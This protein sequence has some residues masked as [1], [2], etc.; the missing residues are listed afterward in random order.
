VG[1]ARTALFNWLFARHHKG[2][3]ILRIEDTDVAR[4][5]VKMM[6][7]ILESLKWLGLEWDEGPY[8]QSQRLSLYPDQANKLVQKG[9]AYYCYC[10]PEELAKRKEEMVQK[11]KAWKYDRK[12]LDLSD[13]KRKELE[14]ESHPKALRFL[15]REGKTSFE[16]GVHGKIERD[17][18]EIEDFI[19]L[20]SDGNPTYN[21]ACVVDDADMNISHV[22]RG[23]DHISNTFKQALLFEALDEKP[24]I[25]CHLPLILGE[26]RSKLSKRHGAISVIDYR[27]QGFLPQAFFNFLALMGW[28]PGDEREFLT[29]EELINDFTLDRVRDSGAIFDVKKLEWMN[30]Q[31]INNMKSE[32]LLEAVLPY[33]KEAGLVDEEL[34]SQKRDWLLEVL[35]LLK[36]RAR[37]L[38][39]FVELGEYFFS[40]KIEYDPKAVKKHFMG[41]GVIKRLHALRDSFD[42]L[43]DFSLSSVEESLRLLADKMGVSASKLI[44][45][46]RVALT[47]RQVGPSLF[48]LVYVMGKERTITRLTQAIQFI[49]KEYSP[50][51]SPPTL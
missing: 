19:I 7:G 3:F 42:K 47:G 29:R 32:E 8:Y 41:N 31:Y 35:Q 28:S 16:D 23:D 37:R 50:Q 15:I 38:T 14:G 1:T 10:S 48:E 25:F 12:C 18:G 4:S 13:E 5:S 11:G 24:P 46:T 22:I 17:N 44:H 2:I 30:G 21:F 33:L 49:E 40:E 51:S 34:L 36:D 45:P 39:D 6:E 43:K 27:D 9:R 20:R 26:D